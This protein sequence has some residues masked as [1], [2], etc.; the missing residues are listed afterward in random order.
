MLHFRL[1]VAVDKPLFVHNE[2]W[3][4]ALYDPP[5]LLLNVHNNLR[6]SGFNFDNQKLRGN[7]LL[8]F[9][10]RLWSANKIGPKIM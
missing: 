4:I 9:L 7:T 8:T 10:S 2:K 5:H 3:I 6:K 1:Q